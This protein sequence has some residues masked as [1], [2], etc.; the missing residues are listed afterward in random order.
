MSVG[1]TEFEGKVPTLDV[2]QITK[3]SAKASTRG[4]PGECE[5]AARKPTRQTLLGSCPAA[6]TGIATSRRKT[7]VSLVRAHLEC[8]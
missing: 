5:P 8:V 7:V 1:P 6:A 3:A 4:S 2:T